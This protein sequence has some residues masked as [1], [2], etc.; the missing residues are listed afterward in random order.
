MAGEYTLLDFAKLYKKEPLKKGVINVFRKHSVMEFLPF[1]TTGTLTVQLFRTKTQPVG[2]TRS[3]GKAFSRLDLADMEPVEERPTFMGGYIDIP[4]EY[5]KA[6]GQIIDQR[7]FQT[8]SNVKGMALK[9]NDMFINGTPSDPESMVGLWY[10]SQHDLDSDQTVL[11]GGLDVS[12]D[13]TS[14]AAN[15]LRLID[16]VDAAIDACEDN[17]CDYIFANRDFYRA[18]LRAIRATGMFAS[19]KDTF[20]RGITTYGE[21][22]P[23]IVD[24]GYF[25]DQKTPLIGNVE[26]TDGT[27]LTGG[28]S[29]SAY[30][31]KVG[32]D[33]YLNAWQ[34][35]ALDAVD[36]GL[37]EDH[38]NYRTVIDWAV[39]LFFVSPRTYS[40]LAGVIAK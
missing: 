10:R 32:G 2:K 13:A 31:V 39:G 22:G 18:L 27:A 36:K 19:D 34:F 25:A 17:T 12:P 29:T 11:A 14:L 6:K 37:L 5:V 28:A 3:I 23:K 1:T 26:A 8:K 9:F 30:F 40:R 38:V 35:D 33:E 20:G 7:A 24:I 16:Y 4:K 15:Q 21:N